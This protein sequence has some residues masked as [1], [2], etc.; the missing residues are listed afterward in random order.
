MIIFILVFSNL[1]FRYP[2][3]CGFRQNGWV[4]CGV[5][6]SYIVSD[7]RSILEALQRICRSVDLG[8]VGVLGRNVWSL[9]RAAL[10][11]VSTL[12]HNQHLYYYTLD[13]PSPHLV[14]EFIY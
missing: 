5:D 3:G 14:P 12:V 2:Y 8:S 6:V 13:W 10:P 1:S 4:E 11:S 7:R 9:L